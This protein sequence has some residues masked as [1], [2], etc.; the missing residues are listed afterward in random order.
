MRK[1]KINKLPKGFKLVDGNIVEDKLMKDGGDLRTGDQANYG[2]VTT[3]QNYF[4]D[5]T[6]NNSGDES[7]RYSLSSVPRDNA[8][9]EAEGGETVLTDLNDNGDF[10]LYNITGPRHSQGGVPMFL[11]EQSF[12]YSDTP[13]L[14][15][16]KDEMTE[17]S[18]GGDKKTPAKISSK[19]GLNEYYAELDSDYADNISSRSAELMLKK[20]MEDLSK[21]AFM[22]ESKKDF[23]DGVPL[24]SHPYLMSVGVDPLEFTA[25]MEEISV[26]Q[27]RQKAIAALSPAEQEQL[28]YLQMMIQQSQQAQPQQEGNP[29]GNVGPQ[30]QMAMQGNPEQG[31]IDQMD[32]ASA[33]NDMMQSARFGSELGDFLKKAQGGKELTSY[34]DRGEVKEEDW[35]DSGTSTY[36]INGQIVDRAT[37]LDY[38]IRNNM[39]RGTIDSPMGGGVREDFLAGMSAEERAMYAKAL[40]PIEDYDILNKESYKWDGDLSE[41]VTVE[42]EPEVEVTDEMIS[43]AT[44]DGDEP[45]GMANPYAEDGT[46]VTT[47]K[48]SFINPYAGIPGQEENARKL[49]KYH[50]DGYTITEKDGKIDIFKAGTSK[51]EKNTNNRG[52]GS[53]TP[54]DGKGVPI[55]NK[56]IEGQGDVVNE[57][58]IGRYRYGSLSEGSRDEQQGTTGTSSY[59]SADIELEVN[60]V[61]FEDRWGDV[62][63]T[64]EG[65]NYAE[66]RGT[67]QYKKQWTAFQTQA[68][69]KRKEEAAA[70]DIPYVPYFKQKSDKD[71]VRGESADGA[72]GLHTFNTP[73]L[74]VDYTQEE[75]ISMDL[76][77]KPKDPEK[78]PTL[79]TPEGIPKRWWAQD[80]NNLTTLASLDDTL[81]TPFGVPIERQKIDYVLDD[82]AGQV[83]ANNSNLA[84]MASALTA[85]GGPQALL[86]SNVFGKT[87][88]ANAKA[89]MAVNQKNVQTMNRVATLQPQL[90]M[91]VDMFN[92]KMN[93]GVYDNTNLALENLEQNNNARKIKA[94]ELFNQ[95]ATNAANTYNLNQLYDNYNI[96]PSVYGDAE[97]TQDG[98]KL[99]KE[100]Q[101]DELNAYFDKVAEYEVKT[102]KA[103]PDKLM[104]Q[105]YPGA[106]TN[107][108]N[109]SA[110][111][112]EYRKNRDAGNTGGYNSNVNVQGKKGKETKSIPRWAV[113][114]YTGK[115]GI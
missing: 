74:D 90:D 73:R 79:E 45:I 56:D 71:Y 84:E 46:K 65:F 76:P 85:A 7:V 92:N 31:S 33:N 63:K 54:T 110:A 6:F 112:I 109:L 52:S 107:D 10:G 20:N 36:E 69:A 81:R 59:G 25:K 101:K 8:N 64:I 75:R 41:E 44:I 22:Q 91:K 42:V 50:D 28:Q 16:T 86:R 102:G 2:L 87:M 111:Q 113:P 39:H 9:I 3:P 30:E 68:E 19:F 29:Q 106:V 34:Q 115:A 11:P 27:A 80:E 17:F 15:F 95:G 72:F 103:M 35:I 1:I 51:W 13:K 82:W 60:K 23:E 114:F 94:N 96:N 100:T 24:A 47:G 40:K 67:P 97:F 89:Q 53:G 5:T 38:M 70:M 12:I 43:G 77:D 26:E 4:G 83:G 58:G 66:P 99:V 108:P 57:S 32:L 18:M 88:D 104:E 98:R 55:Y 105:L 61:D 37:W 48:D 93:Q 62:T 49:Q 21:L 14:K 78:T